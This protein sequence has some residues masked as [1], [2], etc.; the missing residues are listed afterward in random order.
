MHC[1]SAHLLPLLLGT[2]DFRVCPLCPLKRRNVRQRNLY[3]D[4]CRLCVTHQLGLMSIGVIVMI[5]F[6]PI[7]HHFTLPKV[8]KIQNLPSAIFLTLR[9]VPTF[10]HTTC[11]W[12]QAN[13]I[14]TSECPVS[15]FIPQFANPAYF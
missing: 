14:L 7:Q 13:N 15:P 1:N 11:L 4:A 10:L 12:V 2:V 8:N 3:A 9:L 6:R 5:Y